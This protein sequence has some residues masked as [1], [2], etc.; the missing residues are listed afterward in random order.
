MHATD[1]LTVRS[2]IPR[3]SWRITRNQL[4]DQITGLRKVQQRGTAF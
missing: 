2:F 3:A 4:P 1:Y